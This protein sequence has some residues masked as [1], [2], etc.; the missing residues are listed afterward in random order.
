MALLHNATINPSKP[1][2]LGDWVPTQPWGAAGFEVLG[3]YRFDDPDGEVGIETHLLRSADGPLL[4]AP[5]TYRPAPLV[6]GEQHLVCTMEHSVLG[7]RWIYDACGDPVYVRTLASVLLVGAP[8]S[9]LVVD[10]GDGTRQTREPSVRVTVTGGESVHDVPP[11]D[12]VI[13]SSDTVA[14]VIE[15]GDL[16]FVLRRRL[17]VDAPST[18]SEPVLTGVWDGAAEPVLLAYVG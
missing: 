7:K 15:S 5:L 1:Q 13:T 2:L 9:E 18:G 12:T 4:Q 8:Q 17:D 16:R 10:M 6:G 14:T 11:I 3:A